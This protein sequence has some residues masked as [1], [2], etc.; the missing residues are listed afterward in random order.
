MLIYQVT[1]FTMVIQSPVETVVSSKTHIPLNNLAM[2]EKR[3]I[4]VSYRCVYKLR[5]KYMIETAVPQ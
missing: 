2:D 5:K 1:V 4:F 3:Q